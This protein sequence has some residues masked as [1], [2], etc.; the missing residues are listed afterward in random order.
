MHRDF[1]RH[2]ARQAFRR[3]APF[4]DYGRKEP[5]PP[6]AT[7]KAIHWVIGNWHLQACRKAIKG[8]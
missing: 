7:A 4:V 1:V 8:E 6:N 3:G 2:P 5:A